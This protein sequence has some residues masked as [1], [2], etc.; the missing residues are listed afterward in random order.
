MN[1]LPGNKTDSMWIQLDGSFLNLY[2]WANFWVLTELLVP[3]TAGSGVHLSTNQDL[4]ATGS[5]MNKRFFGKQL[6][7]LHMCNAC[8][9]QCHILK[10][11]T[12][13]THLANL[14][15][16]CEPPGTTDS[17]GT[18]SVN[19]GL[20]KGR[21]VKRAQG[22]LLGLTNTWE[23]CS[24]LQPHPTCGTGQRAQMEH[25]SVSLQ[26]FDMFTTQ[27]TVH[28]MCVPSLLEQKVLYR[29]SLLWMACK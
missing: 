2:H 19:C 23:F 13:L 3:L 14:R 29:V 8:Y 4:S 28:E 17:C 5:L 25:W 26:N 15:V 12:K 1:F 11:H 6:Y 18:S 24:E 21:K 20:G 22:R 10:I 27:K 9:R 16:P 7:V